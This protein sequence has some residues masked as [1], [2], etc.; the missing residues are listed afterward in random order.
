[1]IWYL[2]L[3]IVGRTIVGRV[4]QLP[5]GDGSK[6]GPG[7][8]RQVGKWRATG[9]LAA[10]NDTDLGSEHSTRA[11]AMQAV[12]TWHAANQGKTPA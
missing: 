12:A 7:E 4:H 5:A 2:D 10:W 11:A 8:V 3:A 6:T 9:M 1:M